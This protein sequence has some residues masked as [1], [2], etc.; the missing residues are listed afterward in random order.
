MFVDVFDNDLVVCSVLG[1]GNF[2]QVFVIC[3]FVFVG[4]DVLLNGLYGVMLWQFVQIDVVECVDVFKG[5]NVFLNGV[6]LNG[7]VVGG[8]VNL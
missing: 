6:L 7:L 2:L 5:V 1:Y 8:G 4:D 3:G